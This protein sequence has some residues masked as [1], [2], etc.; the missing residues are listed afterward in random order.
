MSTVDAPASSTLTGR[1]SGLAGH[2]G[3]RGVGGRRGDDSPLRSPIAFT[4]ITPRGRRLLRCHRPAHGARHEPGVSLVR[5]RGWPT[6]AC[7]SPDV[8]TGDATRRAARRV[9]HDYPS[10]SFDRLGHQFR[11]HLAVRVRSSATDRVRSTAVMEACL[12]PERPRSIGSMADRSVIGG[13]LRFPSRIRTTCLGRRRVRGAPSTSPHRPRRDG[14]SR[15]RTG[16]RE[17]RGRMYDDAV[18]RWTRRVSYATR[19]PLLDSVFEFY[20]TMA[21]MTVASTFRMI[22]PTVPGETSSSSAMSAYVT[23][24]GSSKYPRCTA[25]RRVSRCR[26]V[27]WEYSR[28]P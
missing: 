10:Q 20:G 6:P 13:L 5:Y 22:V 17:T 27:N 25:T 7:S 11:R 21:G 24:L 1:T 28:S 18:A 14:R 12:H 15:G 8:A 4:R 2:L 23:L 9:I 26:S 3:P 16:Q 19:A